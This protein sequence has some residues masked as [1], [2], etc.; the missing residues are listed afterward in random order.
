[1][2]TWNFKYISKTRLAQ[3]FSQLM[4]NPV[5]GDILIRI[6]TAI[7]VE[8][9]AV[10]LAKFIA[11]LVP[12]AHIFGT[13][14]SAVIVSGKLSPDQ[15]VISVTQMS[16]GGKIRTAL[17]PTFDENDKPIK[18]EILCENVKSAVIDK[19]TKLLLN[20]LTGKYLDV[21]NYVEKCN[22]CFPNVQMIGGL[23]NTPEISLRNFI[24]SGFVFN[25]N[26]W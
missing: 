9:E 10:D 2:F 24:D 11:K 5:K 13:S 26:G 4:L 6:H 15:C 19:N 23:A 25:E 12:G 22:T 17:I 16:A 3:A 18:P 8:D 14:T 1:M 21:Y 7:H 20:F